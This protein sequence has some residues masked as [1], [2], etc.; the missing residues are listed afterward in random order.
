ML[1]TGERPPILV[2]ADVARQLGIAP[3]AFDRYAHRDAIRRA[4]VTKAMQAGGFVG[5]DRATARHTVTF[6]TAAAQTIVRPG[7]LAGILVTELRRMRVMLPSAL[8][9]E[10][11]IRSAR[12][13]AERLGHEVLVADLDDTTLARLDGLLGM[14]PTGKLS[15]LGWLRNAPQSPAPT[16]VGRLLDRLVHVRSLAVDRARMATIPGPVFARLADEATRITA[17]TIRRSSSPWS[18]QG[19]AP[20]AI[21]ATLLAGSGLL[22]AAAG[23]LGRLDLWVSLVDLRINFDTVLTATAPEAERLSEG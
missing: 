16:N 9:L 18:R 12:A 14:R 13:R 7:Q 17:T 2:I 11:V 1:G 5:F 19:R 21:A 6:L 10:A 3:D 22:A 8:V 4:H 20:P 23:L 15:W